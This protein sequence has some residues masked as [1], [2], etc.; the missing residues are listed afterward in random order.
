MKTRKPQGIQ[1][2]IVSIVFGA[3]LLIANLWMLNNGK[4][5]PVMLAITPPLILSGI[6]YLL[7][8]G[9]NP[10]PEVPEGKRVVTWWKISPLKNKIVWILAILV[11]SF[12]GVYL[13]ITYTSFI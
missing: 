2:G 4:V 6:M 9:T 8:P 1:M 11:G 10:A 3:I 7:M 5:F 12:I 13:M